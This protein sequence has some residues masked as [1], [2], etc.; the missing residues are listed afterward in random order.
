MTYP[1]LR[2]KVALI[3]GSTGGVGLETA[4]KLA[5]CGAIVVINGRSEE[6][7]Q[8]ALT[9]LRAIS[10]HVHFALGDVGEYDQAVA[11]ATKAAAVR[12]HIDMLVVAGVR[13]KVRPMPFAEI[14]GADIEGALRSRLLARLLPVHACVPH[15]RKHG[16]SV[17]LMGTDAA[18]HATAG[19]SLIGAAGAA[20]IQ[21]TKVLA[22]EYARWNI[23]VNGIA[24]T[25]TSDTPSWD[26]IF[27]DEEA[28]FDAR[29]FSRVAEKFPWGRAPT[30]EEVARVAMLL[31]SQET[32]QVTGQTLSVNGGLSF[33][34]W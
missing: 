26:R 13:G 27:K 10:P 25:L 7:G 22:K 28:K 33:G 20:V 19:E 4:R 17:V 2:D 31:L 8:A 5:Q 23:R 30:A 24:L 9:T 15:L 32:A 6:N 21:V 1:D 14:P 34:G 16:G 29:L 12:G 18:R 3:T 11:V